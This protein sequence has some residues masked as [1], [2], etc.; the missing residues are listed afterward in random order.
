MNFFF[1]ISTGGDE[2]RERPRLKCT[3]GARIAGTTAGQNGRP[4]PVSPA[5]PSRR[6]SVHLWRGPDQLW[7]RAE[8]V[9][10][11]GPAARPATLYPPGRSIRT[12]NAATIARPTEREQ[13]GTIPF[14]LRS[15]PVPKEMF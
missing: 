7:P 12:R 14:R 5:R 3:V 9:F 10:S 8:H 6:Y 1:L 4:T 15:D 13:D 2:W 11:R